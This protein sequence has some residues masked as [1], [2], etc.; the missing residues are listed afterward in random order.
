MEFLHICAF[1]KPL[2]KQSE[3]GGFL[4]EFPYHVAS[5]RNPYKNQ[6]KWKEFRMHFLNF[7]AFMKPLLKPSEMD[8]FW[9]EV[10][11]CCVLRETLIKTKAKLMVLGA[12]G[13]FRGSKG[14]KKAS[15]TLMIHK[16]SAKSLKKQACTQNELKRAYNSL[17]KS[18]FAKK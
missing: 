11:D 14:T 9:H 17:S 13:A 1:A 5:S 8:A 12:P 3:M 4:H 10:R 16:V 7:A 2:L 18:S 15:Q 6:A